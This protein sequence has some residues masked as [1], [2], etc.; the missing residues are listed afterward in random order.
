MLT[1]EL[2]RHRACWLSITGEQR[3]ASGHVGPPVAPGASAGAPALVL[4]GYIPFS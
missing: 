4:L 3:E 2:E 1:V